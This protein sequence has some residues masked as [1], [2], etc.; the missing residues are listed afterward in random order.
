[1]GL[2]MYL[3]KKKKQE[4]EK[5]IE[6]VAYWRKANQIHNWF[7]ENVQDGVDNCEAYPVTKTNIE[8][9]L[10]I[11]NEI[12]A[13]DINYDEQLT[14]VGMS[15]HDGKKEPIHEFVKIIDDD[16]AIEQMASLLPTS[17]G[18]FFGSIDYDEYY[19][20]D[21]KDTVEQLN[22]VLELTDFETEELYYNSSW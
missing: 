5:Q 4:Q 15:Y 12:L 7:V 22:H 21:I 8:L 19:I 1:M 14:E 3:Y 10:E 18:F 17:P 6:V 2:D 11:C 9:L 13:I 16:E 20:E